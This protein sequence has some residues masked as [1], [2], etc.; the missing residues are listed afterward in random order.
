MSNNAATTSGRHTGGNRSGGSQRGQNGASAP[1]TFSPAPAGFESFYI[2]ERS[3]VNNLFQAFVLPLH[4][5]LVRGGLRL[6]TNENAPGSAIIPANEVTELLPSNWTSSITTKVDDGAEQSTNVLLLRY[7]DPSDSSVHYEVKVIEAVK[8]SVL[9]VILFRAVNAYGPDGTLQAANTR[10]VDSHSPRRNSAAG[11][12]MLPEYL[13]EHSYLVLNGQGGGVENKA[14]YELYK[15]LEQFENIVWK[16][17]ME[18]AGLN[19]SGL[20]REAGPF[21]SKATSQNQQGRQE[22]QQQQPKQQQQ[23]TYIHVTQPQPAP[24][25]AGGIGGPLYVPPGVPIGGGGLG[26]SDLDPLGGFGAGMIGDPR[27]FRQ[28]APIPFGPGGIGGIMPPPPGA[29]FDPFGPPMPAPRP[30]PGAGG[31]GNNFGNPNPDGEQPPPGFEDM[32]M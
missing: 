20:P 15:N 13:T 29:R 25:P 3:K 30:P 22:E 2:H 24:Y 14:W 8:N 26:R 17:L 28:P 10:D 11:N 21:E 4:W 9:V 31:G 16:Q 12:F 23:P 19:V 18:P 7:W 27:G 6:R 32:F 5:S 1:T